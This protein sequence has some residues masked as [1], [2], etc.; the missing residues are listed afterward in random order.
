MLGEE[1]LAKALHRLRLTCSPHAC[2]VVQIHLFELRDKVVSMDRSRS[3]NVPVP[4]DRSMQINA[5]IGMSGLDVDSDGNVGEVLEK[6]TDGRYRSLVADEQES[7]RV[8]VDPVPATGPGNR[9]PVAGG[10]RGRPLGCN[11]AVMVHDIEGKFKTLWVEPARR[12]RADESGTAIGEEE[13][14]PC[15]CRDREETIGREQE[16]DTRCRLIDVE[17][18]K[19]RTAN[20]H[21]G[22]PW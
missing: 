5:G 18:C 22:H 15:P 8:A 7:G 21:P 17:A 16:A 6:L 19:R 20:D 3:Q 11:A 10:C 9:N 4:I 13:L 1:D 14:V 2:A 12:E